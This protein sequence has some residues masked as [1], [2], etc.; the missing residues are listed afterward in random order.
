MGRFLQLQ[1]QE[2]E[3]SWRKQ[4]PQVLSRL[5]QT[6]PLQTYIPQQGSCLFLPGTTAQDSVPERIDLC[7][8]LIAEQ[9]PELWQQTKGSYVGQMPW[10]SWILAGSY[11]SI[12]GLPSNKGS[13]SAG[14]DP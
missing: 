11:N 12:P 5:P 9:R 7:P 6:P 14:E 10:G 13:C 8:A 2:S 4:A 3:L 1:D